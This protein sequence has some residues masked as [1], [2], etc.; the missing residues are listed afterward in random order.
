MEVRNFTG[1][2]GRKLD[3]TIDSRTWEPHTDKTLTLRGTEP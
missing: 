2:W 1:D 3:R